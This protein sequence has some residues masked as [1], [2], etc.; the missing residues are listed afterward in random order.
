[1]FD[2]VTGQRLTAWNCPA[3]MRAVV[4]SHDGKT[5]A[6]GCDDGEGFVWDANGGGARA[7][8]HGHHRPLIRLQFS[9]HDD[10]LASD[11][12]D[13]RIWLWDP[14]DGRPLVT[15]AGTLAGPF[16][17]DGRWLATR[18]GLLEVAP[19]E[20]RRLIGDSVAAMG[21]TA[22]SPDGRLFALS[23]GQVHLYDASG[24]QPIAVVPFGFG[25]VLFQ[26]ADGALVLYGAGGLVRRPVRVQAGD[27]APLSSAS[28]RT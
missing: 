24:L 14:R 19:A 27:P 7:V 8:L 25:T 17:P 20:C 5:L 16:S 13:G 18:A 26:P 28:R 10:L 6:A 15:T 2:T 22:Y 21:R 9:P 11:G 23:A 3:A 4:W 1:M 12:W